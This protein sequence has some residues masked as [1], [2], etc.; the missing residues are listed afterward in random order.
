MTPDGELIFGRRVVPG[1]AHGKICACGRQRRKYGVVVVEV[2][3]ATVATTATRIGVGI[4]ERTAARGSHHS[5]QIL[6]DVVDD[7][8]IIAIGGQPVEAAVSV[9][10]F[11][12][13]AV[14]WL[15]YGLLS[16]GGFFK[17]FF[18]C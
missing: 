15:R 10:H 1:A 14:I 9:F 2:I 18:S 5:S 7:L 17:R 16:W 3:V 12:S 6:H 13:H 11:E 4:A 8:E